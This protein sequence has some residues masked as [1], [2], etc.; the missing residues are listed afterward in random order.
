LHTQVER[1]G[2]PKS[3]GTMGSSRSEFISE[4]TKAEDLER[5]VGKLF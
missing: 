3:E 2:E 1:G 5:C 4:E